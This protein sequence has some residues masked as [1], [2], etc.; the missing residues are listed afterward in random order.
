MKKPAPKSADDMTLEELKRELAYLRAE[1]DVLKKV[2]GAGAAKTR[3]EK[4]LIVSVLKRKHALNDLLQAAQLARS[5]YYYQLQAKIS[6][7]P[8]Y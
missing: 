1:N 6:F 2:S 3:K 4:A 7:L 8:M 5:V